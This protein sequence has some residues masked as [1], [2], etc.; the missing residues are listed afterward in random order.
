MIVDYRYITYKKKNALRAQ[1]SYPKIVK[2]LST[3][4]YTFMCTLMTV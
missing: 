3:K 2:V 4:N 1:T